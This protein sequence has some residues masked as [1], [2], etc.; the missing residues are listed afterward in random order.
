MLF[1]LNWHTTTTSHLSSSTALG[2]AWPGQE[3]QLQQHRSSSG[4][5]P[6]APGSYQWCPGYIAE[7]TR[8]VHE[9]AYVGVSVSL[10][11][12][13]DWITQEHAEGT[14]SLVVVHEGNQ[15]VSPFECVDGSVVPS[16][17]INPVGFVVVPK[18]KKGRRTERVHVQQG[19]NEVNLHSNLLYMTSPC[20]IWTWQ[21]GF[22]I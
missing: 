15:R 22:Y 19:L 9:D 7:N 1:T 17:V 5:W 18:I 2:S 6:A 13:Q 10:L 14:Y 4:G 20:N 11:R 8:R 3:E 12:W 21:T 16:N